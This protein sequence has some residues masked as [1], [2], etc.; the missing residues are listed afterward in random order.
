MNYLRNIKELQEKYRFIA[1]ES[2]KSAE[3]GT[4]HNVFLSK[5]YVIRFRQQDKDILKRE[6]E[7]LKSLNHLLIPRVLASGT[8][9]DSFYIIENRL[10]GENINLVWKNLSKNNQ[11]SICQSLIG[12]L[13]FLRK[14][15]KNEIFSIRYGKKYKN[16]Y[17]YLVEDIE[18]KEA[19]IRKFPQAQKMLKRILK[20][21]KDSEAKKVFLGANKTLVHGDLIFHNL[22]TDGKTLTG[23]VDWERALFGD[24]DY[25]IFRLMNF[26]LDAKFYKEEGQDSEDETGYLKMLLEE[27]RKS[28]LIQNNEIFAK[29]Y[30]VAKASYYLNGLYWDARSET[31]QKNIE[32]TLREIG[33]KPKNKNI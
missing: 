23:T 13:K 5:I 32:E 9:E 3:S 2:F 31:P 26:E 21:L 30:E 16:F 11:A 12:F 1:A 19:V 29:K 4:I 7:L 20:V 33:L 14:Q 8:I 15:N 25:D 28:D 24:P 18:K 22:L 6:S 27:I 10:R 17:D